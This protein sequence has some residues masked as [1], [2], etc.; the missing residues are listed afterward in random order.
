[1]TDHYSTH[2]A[3]CK[4]GEPLYYPVLVLT[5]LPPAAL[6]CTHPGSLRARCHYNS[7][8]KE[9]GPAIRHEQEARQERACRGG[10]R[11]GADLLLLQVEHR[12]TEVR[13][14]NLGIAKIRPCQNCPDEQGIIQVGLV[15]NLQERRARQR[16]AC[17]TRQR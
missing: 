8:D 17:T 5:P 10:L 3:S 4:N 2:V 12:V 13:S 6:S 11:W 14:F 9:P 1:M 15:Q 16:G 7:T